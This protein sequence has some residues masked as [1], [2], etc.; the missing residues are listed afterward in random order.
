[1][2][3]DFKNQFSTSIADLSSLPHFLMANLQDSLL[4]NKSFFEPNYVP[5]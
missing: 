4:H 1:M 3:T 5:V 2:L